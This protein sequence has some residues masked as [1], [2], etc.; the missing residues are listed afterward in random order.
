[1]YRIELLANLDRVPGTG[2]VALVTFPKPRGRIGVSRTRVR[3]RALMCCRADAGQG[4]GLAAGRQIG[5]D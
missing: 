3:G 4:P 5:Y 1:M 2:A